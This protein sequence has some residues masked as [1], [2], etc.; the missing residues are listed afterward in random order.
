MHL[1]VSEPVRFR[2]GMVIDTI[3]LY[4]DSHLCDLDL[5]SGSRGR[6]RKD[7]CTQCLPKLLMSLDDF[8]M[9]LGLVGLIEEEN[10]A[11]DFTKKKNLDS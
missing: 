6:K 5:D 11:S 9:L 4:L 3:E 8:V 10:A 7:F 2:F 1:D